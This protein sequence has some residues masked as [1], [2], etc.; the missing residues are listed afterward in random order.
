MSG[1]G[2]GS[3]WHGSRWKLGSQPRPRGDSRAPP[4]RWQRRRAAPCPPRR[5]A[6]AGASP[7][8]GKRSLLLFPQ[9]AFVPFVC[10]E[11]PTLRRG[12]S[13]PRG[14]AAG[15]GRP[16]SVPAAARPGLTCRGA[17]AAAWE[18]IRRL[19][20][21]FQRAQFAEVAH[22]WA[23]RRRHR[24]RARRTPRPFP[25]DPGAG[26]RRGPARYGPSA[27]PCQRWEPRA[28]AGHGSDWECSPSKF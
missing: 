26:T 6:P 12:S 28:R 17:M 3:S 27:V 8:R 4:G 2:S 1:F 7:E 10:L 19:A 13:V 24:C 25:R 11:W 22:R 20:A 18:E 9:L 16:R 14:G 15:G 21:D 23:G 5:D